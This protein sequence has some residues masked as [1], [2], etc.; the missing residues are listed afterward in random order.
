MD[1]VAEMIT[2][3]EARSCTTE[4]AAL[5]AAWRKLR[6]FAYTPSIYETEEP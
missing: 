1:D 4:A 5:Y 3:A 6:Y 2:D